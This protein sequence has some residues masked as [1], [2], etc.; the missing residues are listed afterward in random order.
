MGAL[1]RSGGEKRLWRWCFCQS[2]LLFCTGTRPVDTGLPATLAVIRE[3]DLCIG[4]V[5]GGDR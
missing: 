4:Y 2:R 3:I 5:F 1:L